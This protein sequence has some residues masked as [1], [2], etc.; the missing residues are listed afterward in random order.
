[1][2]FRNI[3]LLL[4]SSAMFITLLVC[5]KRNKSPV[6]KAI[7]V[8]P[9]VGEIKENSESSLIS[10]KSVSLDRLLP[11]LHK[12][13]NP[14]KYHAVILR[15]NSPGGS[16]VQAS[17]I[18]KRIRLFSEKKKMPV[19]A[20]IGD[21]GASAAYYI[22]CSADKIYA[23]ENSLV[24]SIGVVSE[25]F[26]VSEIL[27]KL[28]VDYKVITSG[29]NKARLHPFTK[30]KDEDIDYLKDTQK[31]IFDN[32]VKLVK[33]RRYPNDA[34]MPDDIA[35]GDCW[36]AFDA[37]EKGLIDDIDYLNHF[38]DREYGE[39]TKVEIMDVKSI[40]GGLISKLVGLIFSHYIGNSINF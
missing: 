7:V 36:T 40:S 15:I 38:V 3:S 25:V 11:I 16:P 18:Y 24:G 39:D 6:K 8:V 28:L 17:W 26:N 35:S 33:E 2:S 14:D 5:I 30:Q 29:Q 37:K 22:A 19:Y 23:D 10:S 20:F 1:M 9:I 34:I 31:K 32:F 12:A 21:I 4:G 13:F 27:E